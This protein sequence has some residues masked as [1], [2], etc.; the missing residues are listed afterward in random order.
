MKKYGKLLTF[1][2]TGDGKTTA[3][4]GH[5]IRAAGHGKRVVVLHFMKGRENVGEYKYFTNNGERGIKVYLCGSPR[6]LVT[7]ED[8]WEHLVKA[9][10]SI[11]LAKEILADNSCDLLILDEVLYAI[12]YGLIREDD[13][14]SLVKRRGNTHI[15]LTGR[16]ASKRIQ[17][18]SDIVT[19]MNEIKHH[20]NTDKTTI[21]GLDY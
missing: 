12:K 20:Y 6:F 21:L 16:E 15:I 18:A 19:L 2:G 7:I 14:L 4:L 8:K 5:A 1:I 11:E 10:E 3:A 9:K 17:K 13:L